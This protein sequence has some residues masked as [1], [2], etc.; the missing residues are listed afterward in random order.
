MTTIKLCRDCASYGGLQPIKSRNSAATIAQEV[1][2]DPR[3]AFVDYIDGKMRPVDAS[4]L[5]NLKDKDR[6]GP[7]AKWF[8]EKKTVS[9]PKVMVKDPE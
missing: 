4:W 2:L 3:N 1:C 5:R 6:C 7:E 9:E 8:V